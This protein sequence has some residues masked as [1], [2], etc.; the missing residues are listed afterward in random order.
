MDTLQDLCQQSLVSHY[1]HS[2]PNILI[3]NVKDEVEAQFKQHK[4]KLPLLLI[5][6]NS[7]IVS[8][9]KYE[10]IK[11]NSYYAVTKTVMGVTISY[12]VVEF[13]CKD[14]QTLKHIILME[15]KKNSGLHKMEFKIY[16]NRNKIIYEDTNIGRDRWKYTLESIT[17]MFESII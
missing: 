9:I 5:E 14:I 13:I 17:N 12:N 10:I 15:A 11:L 1:K 4:N 2:L 3:E 16:I 8:F 7:N 6:L